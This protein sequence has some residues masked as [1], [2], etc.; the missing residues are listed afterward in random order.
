MV[1]LQN[2][3]RMNKSLQ[4]SIRRVHH[5]RCGVRGFAAGEIQGD[6]AKD[7]PISGTC[8]R[9]HNNDDSGFTE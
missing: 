3:K 9:I 6:P 2:T 1:F 5:L 8:G 4:S 7:R